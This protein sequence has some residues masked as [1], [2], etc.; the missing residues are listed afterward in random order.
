MTQIG[1]DCQKDLCLS[2][3]VSL[4]HSAGMQLGSSWAEACVCFK[5]KSEHKEN[6]ITTQGEPGIQ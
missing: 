6:A 2:A 1:S 4:R 3:E 5:E